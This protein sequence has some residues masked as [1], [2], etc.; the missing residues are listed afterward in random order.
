MPK[1]LEIKHPTRQVVKANRLIEAKA[2]LT[3]MEN[4]I[5][6]SLVA[7]IDKGDQKFGVVS[8][9]V[10]EILEKSGANNRR[11]YE[12]AKDICDRLTEKTIGVE[13][14]DE[15]GTRTYRSVS[16]FSMCEY[17][18]GEGKIRARFSVDMEP[19]LL[20]LKKRFTMYLLQFFL[21]LDSKHS[22]RIYE[23]LKMREGI[24]GMTIAVERFREILGLE[25][26]Y[27]RFSQ[28]KRSVLE[29]A[30]EEIK[31]KTDI[32]F[33][34]EVKRDGQTPVAIK[35]RVHNQDSAFPKAAS[36]GR[37][38]VVE[39]A[40]KPAS[41][42]GIDI[43]ALDLFMESL[44]QSEIESSDRSVLKEIEKEA[45]REAKRQN[46]ERSDTVIVSETLR[47]MRQKWEER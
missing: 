29:R 14:E 11:F 19:L 28:L 25:D 30:R 38:S 12:R 2:D 21:R 3:K 45:R 46:E 33:T 36:P 37:K 44:S 31:E 8:V 42:R 27:E 4:Q 39:E 18:E 35:F 13:T 9:S 6:A 16:L 1:Q 20:Q 7:E 10:K 43:R 22:M 5:F 41:S 47:I 15:R 23:M 40:Q 17:T 32:R 26:K 34:Y 24:H